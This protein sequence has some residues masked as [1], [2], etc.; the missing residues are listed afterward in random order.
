MEDLYDNYFYSINFD[1]LEPSPDFSPK[2]EESLLGLKEE[3]SGNET[4]EATRENQ[5][6]MDKIQNEKLS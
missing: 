4:A 3:G 5:L 2:F 6:I 1:E